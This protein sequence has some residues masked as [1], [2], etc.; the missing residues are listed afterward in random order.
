MCSLYNV[1]L[2]TWPFN[3]VCGPTTERSSELL[4]THLKTTKNVD[5]QLQTHQLANAQQT[6]K[7]QTGTYFVSRQDF[8]SVT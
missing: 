6:G 2:L 4:F 8:V 3:V 1:T 5:T 7:K